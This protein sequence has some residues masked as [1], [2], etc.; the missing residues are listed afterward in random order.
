M[1]VAEVRCWSEFWLIIKLVGCCDGDIQLAKA[2]LGRNTS[3]DGN[4]YSV[5]V[6]RKC[7]PLH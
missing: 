4:R 5:M 7:F 1:A 2:G 6:D 3:Y